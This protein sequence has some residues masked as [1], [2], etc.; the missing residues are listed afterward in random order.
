MDFNCPVGQF[1]LMSIGP[2][3]HTDH[4][5]PM[6]LVQVLDI[7][8]SMGPNMNFVVSTALA[9]VDMLQ[10]GSSLRIIVF[11]HFAQCIVPETIIKQANKQALK[12]IIKTSISNRNGGTDIQSALTHALIGQDQSIMF[13]TDGV[14]NSGS[15]TES[16]DLLYMARR[17]PD[18][19]SNTIHCLGLQAWTTDGINSSLLK[20]L[21][22]DTNGYFKIG[23]EPET[24]ASFLGDVFAAHTMT[25]RRN[26]NTTMPGYTL[27]SAVGINGYTV[28][29]DRPT[30]L[31]FKHTGASDPT[32]LE[33]SQAQSQ[34]YSQESQDTIAEEDHLRDTVLG[35]YVSYVITHLN[36]PEGL[37]KANKLLQYLRGI[38]HPLM[39]QLQTVLLYGGLN[40]N[41]KL[42]EEVYNL[43]TSS[44]GDTQQVIDF[45][46]LALETSLQQL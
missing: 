31:V 38:Q 20:D 9:A 3:A 15:L 16:E 46:Q 42:S 30:T 5:R 33:N 41:A 2:E 36:G 40:D 37:K 21:A 1:K 17:M 11:D 19:A 26:C 32:D 27:I 43:S 35:S 8:G 22:L 39:N 23:K 45:R 7:S 14:A 24:I 4:V 25:V 10:E 18:Y 13:L 6:K 34:E 29:S 12:D 44:C 28:R